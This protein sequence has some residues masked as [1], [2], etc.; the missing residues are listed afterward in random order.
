MEIHFP[1]KQLRLCAKAPRRA[2]W[3]DHN[4]FETL[5]TI[6]SRLAPGWPLIARLI[7]AKG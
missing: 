6:A 3:H 4:T 5:A 2:H 1:L 7:S